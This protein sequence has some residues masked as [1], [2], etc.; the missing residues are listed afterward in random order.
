MAKTG[1][2]LL[3]TLAILVLLFVLLTGPVL[4]ASPSL[5]INH[6][7]QTATITAIS[8]THG[9]LS[10]TQSPSSSS[11]HSASETYPNK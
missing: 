4:V 3:Q 10:P 5:V 1:F 11:S 6:N 7:T 9:L 2:I 8:T